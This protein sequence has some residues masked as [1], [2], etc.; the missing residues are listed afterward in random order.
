ML[1]DK[2]VLSDD[3]Y[4]TPPTPP[5]QMDIYDKNIA[6]KHNK[7]QMEALVE[8]AAAQ[9]NEP[10]AKQIDSDAKQLLLD[11][12]DLRRG[13]DGPVLTAADV[14]INN[15]DIDLFEN[16]D[17]QYKNLIS[18]Y[19]TQ[20]SGLGSVDDLQDVVN[21]KL[22]PE[23]FI[24][25]YPDGVT[26]LD[27]S[28]NP[29]INAEAPIITNEDYTFEESLVQLMAAGNGNLTI[30]EKTDTTIRY[31]VEF[32]RPNKSGNVML[33]LFFTKLSDYSGRDVF[34][35]LTTN[36]KQVINAEYGGTVARTTHFGQVKENGKA[37]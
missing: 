13:Q 31:R 27:E 10:L 36:E 4:Y 35:I 7:D 30:V 17:S 2:I 6:L 9:G 22:A 20:I 11:E 8:I 24:Q 16:V 1:I 32:P 37:A 26:E 28:E 19:I 34:A 23:G 21:G 12:I 29:K 33:N 18:N 15:I 3:A 25:D 5:E 14:G